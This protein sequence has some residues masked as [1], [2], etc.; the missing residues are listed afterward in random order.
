MIAR[1]FE[2]IDTFTVGHTARTMHR[3]FLICC[4]INVFR[5]GI[6]RSEWKCARIVNRG[7][8]LRCKAPVARPSM[9]SLIKLVCIV[10]ALPQPHRIHITSIQRYCLF[11]EI[12][13]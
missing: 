5:T 6:L 1:R 13:F 10:V 4:S 3:I 9:T 2:I 8:L 7:A 12:L 11:H